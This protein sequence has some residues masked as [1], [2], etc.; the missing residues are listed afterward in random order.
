MYDM[1]L[2][3]MIDINNEWL[4]SDSTFNMQLTAYTFRLWYANF[5]KIIVSTS[6][7]VHT[8]SSCWCKGRIY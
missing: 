6:G 2:K 7:R 4:R 3:C 8:A 5:N 1:T